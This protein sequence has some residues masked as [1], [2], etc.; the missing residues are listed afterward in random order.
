MG[1]GAEMVGPPRVLCGA[2]PDR[3]ERNT[4]PQDLVVGESIR[5]WDSKTSTLKPSSTPRSPSTNSLLRHDFVPQ[6]P[7]VFSS[8]VDPCILRRKPFH[9]IDRG[10]MPHWCKKPSPVVTSK[11]NNASTANMAALPFQVSALLVQPHSHTVT[12]GGSSPRFESYAA[13]SSSTL[14]SGTSDC[15]HQ[16]HS[17]IRLYNN[18]I[19]I[20]Q[21]TVQGAKKKLNKGKGKLLEK[22]G[23][24][25]NIICKNGL[26]FTVQWP[27]VCGMDNIDQLDL[28]PK[29]TSYLSK[30]R[31]TTNGSITFFAFGR[32][33]NRDKLSQRLLKKPEQ[34]RKS[35]DMIAYDW[36]RTDQAAMDSFSELKVS[37]NCMIQHQISCV[38]KKNDPTSELSMLLAEEPWHMQKMISYPKECQC[39]IIIMKV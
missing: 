34:P 30:W 6:N 36:M 22:M 16:N 26:T 7:S 4:F 11:T 3:R 39:P 33:N 23:K 13:R 29:L 21:D 38:A 10:R 2:G 17:S 25:S 24:N 32:P 5:P 20:L 28:E 18:A 31:T 19:S 1:G 9:L 14:P 35:N 37:S 27:M 15:R 12:G 8:L